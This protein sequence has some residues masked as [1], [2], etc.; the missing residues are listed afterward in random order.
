MGSVL[1]RCST[2]SMA[3]SSCKSVSRTSIILRQRS[4]NDRKNIRLSGE[5][6]AIAEKDTEKDNKEIKKTTEKNIEKVEQKATKDLE[7]SKTDTL[8]SIVA[9][10]S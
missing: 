9:T 4:R 6:V 10:K 7:S 1:D 8:E 3:S 5:A 2:L